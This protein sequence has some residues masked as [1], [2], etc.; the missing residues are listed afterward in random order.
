MRF[1]SNIAP[2]ILAPPVFAAGLKKHDPRTGTDKKGFTLLELLLVLLIVGFASGLA[3]IALGD[4]KGKAELKGE[5]VRIY[6]TLR[7]LRERSLLE[8]I[9][10]ALTADR[11]AGTL[12]TLRNGRPVG[13][14]RA[15]PDGLIIDGGPAVF[16][17]KGNAEALDFVI[18]DKKGR[19]FTI[20]LDRV[21]GTPTVNRLQ[22]P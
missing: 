22:S 13:T 6:S 20:A 2:Q 21:T 14:P 1:R 12:T 18:K 10:Y 15:V 3:L 11:E 19:G 16:Y 5:A 4:T 17:P 9:P 7:H 8:R